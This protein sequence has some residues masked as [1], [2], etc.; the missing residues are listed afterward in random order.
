MVFRVS[1]YPPSPEQFNSAILLMIYEIFVYSFGIYFFHNWL[2]KSQFKTIQFQKSN[3][4][5]WVFILLT[6]LIVG[7]LLIL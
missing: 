1:E 6:C 3:I 2:I 4:I 5:Y 7:C